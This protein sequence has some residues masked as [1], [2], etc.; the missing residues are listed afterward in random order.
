MTAPRL[1]SGVTVPLNRSFNTGAQLPARWKGRLLSSLLFLS[2]PASAWAEALPY[3]AIDSF[4]Y[5]EPVTIDAASREWNTTDYTPGKVQWSSHRVEAGVRWNQRK[6]GYLYR[7]DMDLRFNRATSDYYYNSENNRPVT[8]SSD[9]PLTLYAHR[10]SA[11]GFRLGHSQQINSVWSLSL[12][13]SLFNADDLIEGQVSGSPQS[14]EVDYHYSEDTLLDRQVARPKGQ[15]ASLD[16]AAQ[17]QGNSS[18]MNLQIYDL[19]GSIWWRNAPYTQ[20]QASADQ[21]TYND[22]GYL[23]IKPLLTGFEGTDT[24]Y[25]QPLKPQIHWQAYREIRKTEWNLGYYHRD[26]VDLWSIGTRFGKGETHWGGR[27]WP[28]IKALE[29]YHQ[30]A[31]IKASLSLDALDWSDTQAL[32]LKLEIL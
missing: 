15:G 9:T 11:T 18:A 29:I 8:T 17:W 4:S 22:E 20:A 3:F 24:R 6:L 7:L 30:S 1:L 2:C 31:K 19:L 27:W 23:V 26:R 13:G 28:Q 10:F 5:S 16:L 25:R 14:L 21:N 32:W 12:S